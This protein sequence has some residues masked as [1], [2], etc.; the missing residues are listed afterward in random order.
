MIFWEQ[1]GPQS[2]KKSQLN[3]KKNIT[4]ESVELGNNILHSRADLKF[5]GIIK[6]KDIN[7]QSHTKLIMKIPKVE[8]PYQSRTVYDCFQWKSYI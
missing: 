6:G 7:F 2:E 5:P 1:H 4:N 3:D 8:C